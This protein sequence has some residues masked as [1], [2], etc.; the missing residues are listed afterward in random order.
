MGKRVAIEAGPLDVLM[1]VEDGKCYAHCLP[2][3]LLGEGDKPAEALHNLADMIREHLTFY[4]ERGIEEF[5]FCPAPKKY[6]DMLKMVQEKKRCIPQI[7]EGLLQAKT[8][9]RIEKFLN[10]VNVPAIA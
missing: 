2:F 1:S 9:N 5:I 4:I 3:D 7:P 6:W 10:P 8:S